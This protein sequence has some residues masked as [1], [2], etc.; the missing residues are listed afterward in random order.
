MTLAEEN[1]ELH[2]TLILPTSLP[3][4]SIKKHAFRI[5][6]L[7]LLTALSY[8][9]SQDLQFEHLTVKD[10]LSNNSGQAR[11]YVVWHRARIE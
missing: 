8:S 9:Q 10:G 2:T 3:V 6:F 7:V 4:L 5:T 11:L 1:F